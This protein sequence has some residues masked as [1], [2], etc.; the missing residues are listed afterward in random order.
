MRCI[1]SNSAW[2]EAERGPK[3]N[4]K[5]GPRRVF[6]GPRQAV[7][8]QYL[9]S[10]Y[11]SSEFQPANILPM[12]EAILTG[13]G[14]YLVASAGIPRHASLLCTLFRVYL[15]LLIYTLVGSAPLITH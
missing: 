13:A 10:N 15:I 5:L 14:H 9:I 3:L 7:S 4:L 11:L 6:S 8:P 2:Y 12:Q 1:C